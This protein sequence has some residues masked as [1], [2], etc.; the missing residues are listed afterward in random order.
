LADFQWVPSLHAPHTA[1]RHH[2]SSSSSH[3]HSHFYSS[4][5][6]TATSPFSPLAPLLF[7][8]KD[9]PPDKLLR[10]FDINRDAAKPGLYPPAP[11]PAA[12][13]A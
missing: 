4:P 8:R 1:A 10:A 9:N 3:S 2:A 12:A 13:A 6:P 5:A 11:A 7:T